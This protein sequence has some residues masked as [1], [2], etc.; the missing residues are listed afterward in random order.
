M[1]TKFESYLSDEELEELSQEIEQ[2]GDEG[3]QTGLTDAVIKRGAALAASGAAKLKV[4]TTLGLSVRMVDKLYKSELFRSTVAS[5]A[6]DA[7]AAAK[8]KTRT[9]ISRMQGKAMKALEANLDK[10]S[11]EAVKTWLKAVG[12]DQE[13]EGDDKGGPLTLI[14]ANQPQPQPTTVV[15]KKEGEE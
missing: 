3:P 14:L 7:V 2:A 11:L 15:V 8:N 10:N 4:R 5:I 6:D 1:G 9:D 13:K 12:M